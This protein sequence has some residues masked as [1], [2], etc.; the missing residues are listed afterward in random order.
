MSPHDI[1]DLAMAM[2]PRCHPGF[3]QVIFGGVI[4]CF[5]FFFFSLVWKICTWLVEGGTM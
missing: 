2:E 4:W 3:D 5:I 1:L